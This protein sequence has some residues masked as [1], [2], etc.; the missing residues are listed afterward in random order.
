MNPEDLKSIESFGFRDHW[1]GLPYS[2]KLHGFALAQLLSPDTYD[3]YITAEVL[4]NLAAYRL[5]LYAPILKD[6]K[7]LSQ[8]LD[9]GGRFEAMEGVDIDDSDAASELLKDKLQLSVELMQRALDIKPD[10][11]TTSLFL[12][13]SGCEIGEAADALTITTLTQRIEH[14][15]E[16]A[17]LASLYSYDQD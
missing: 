3:S 15:H 12:Y 9:W 17:K 16:I 8:W 10:D 5:V 11:P 1:S 2:A 7:E 6:P 4:R 14:A 13:A